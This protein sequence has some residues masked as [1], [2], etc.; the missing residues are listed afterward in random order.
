MVTCSIRGDSTTAFGPEMC[1]RDFVNVALLALLVAS[2][3]AVGA[4]CS[5][6]GSG[7]SPTC[8]PNEIRRCMCSE[9]RPG[10]QV[11]QSDR[12]FG[13][14][15]CL[16]PDAVA[17]DGWSSR[18]CPGN[19]AGDGA[20]YVAPDGEQSAPGTRSNPT[21]PDAALGDLEAGATV[22]F[23]EGD[24]TV[25][26]AP[27]VSGTEEEPIV[28]RSV[29]PGAATIDS[30][31][32]YAFDLQ[33]VEHYRLH[34]FDFGSGDSRWVRTRGAE[35]VRLS[36]LGLENYDGAEGSAPLLVA[37]SRHIELLDS[38]V[39]DSD[40]P[41]TILV[42]DG[43][44]HVLVAGNDFTRTAE[45]PLRIRR[46]KRILVRGN[47]FHNGT[48]P[49]LRIWYARRVTVDWNVFTNGVDGPRAL[50]AHNLI[51]GNNISFRHNRIFRN[52][53]TV[54]RVEGMS[55]EDADCPE[56]SPGFNC[57]ATA[58]VQVFNNVIDD[59]RDR[60]AGSGVAIRYSRESRNIYNQRVKN[61]LVSRVGG[62]RANA[63]QFILPNPAG[64]FRLLGNAFWPGSDA[65][66][67][68]LHDGNE[69][70]VDED[71]GEVTIGRKSDNRVVEPEVRDLEARDYR[72][73]ASSPLVDGGVR[74]TRTDKSPGFD[75]DEIKGCDFE[76]A[77]L[78]VENHQ[79]FY[80]D[81]SEG[82][83]DRVAVGSDGN[84]ARLEN[85]SYCKYP[86]DKNHHE[87]S[88]YQLQLDRQLS[89][90]SGERFGLA[91]AGSAVDVG[92]W[93]RGSEERSM[94][95][96]DRDRYVAETG[97]LVQLRAVV[98]G[99][100][101]AEQFRWKF[102]DGVE[103]CGRAVTHRYEEGGDYGIRLQVVDDEGTVHRAADHILVKGDA[104]DPTDYDYHRR[105]VG[106]QLCES[107]AEEDPG[108]GL[109]CEGS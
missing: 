57:E 72:P 35:H 21:S 92:A 75:F 47:V 78:Y 14:C 80:D 76:A 97:E 94:V 70:R 3:L 69:Y 52:W 79:Y 98:S 95:G 84:A 61:N 90:S 104:V 86:G 30:E 65:P 34:G 17:P 54:L 50:G 82:A 26:V 108:G 68:V 39:A 38:S 29:T 24:Y 32:E 23:L 40:H 20:T 85:T 74:L 6:G 81:S 22:V 37:D 33:G 11:C 44:L 2:T 42:D 31:A 87:Q 106:E 56:N 60:G 93:E 48:G 49:N 4:G 64:F 66:P 58:H 13:A 7:A 16:A 105:L 41:Q 1:T 88:W 77:A 100:V 12:T 46:S 43:S 5:E 59:V 51:R 101:D 27:S 99:G 55:A 71:S 89:W 45:W 25:E 96:I 8:V 67:T 73:R 19:S 9:G 53:G 15:R 109:R 62:S 102:G 36:E 28:L 18:Q 63:V 83:A 103:R 91:W 107:D 10:R